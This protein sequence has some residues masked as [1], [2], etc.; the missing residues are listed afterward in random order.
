VSQ[1][2]KSRILTVLS[3]GIDQLQYLPRILL[4]DIEFRVDVY[5]NGLKPRVQTFTTSTPQDA[6]RSRA[7]SASPS[8]VC[9]LYIQVLLI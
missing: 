9:M 4:F 2:K 8:Q 6:D 5:N 1:N 3:L 7:G